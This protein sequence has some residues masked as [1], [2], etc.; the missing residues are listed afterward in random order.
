VRNLAPDEVA[1]ATSEN[2]RRFFGLS[3]PARFA[4]PGNNEKS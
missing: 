3:R 4:A 2:F 1:S